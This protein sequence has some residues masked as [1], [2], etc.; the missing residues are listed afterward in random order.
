[1]IEQA[2]IDIKKVSRRGPSS[3]KTSMA[4]S[5]VDEFLGSGLSAAK[6]EWE[7]F[8]KDFD[9][10]KKAISYR[11]RWSKVNKLAGAGDLAMRSDRESGE[12]YLVHL[13]M[14]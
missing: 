6:V 12:V 10:A 1:M 8:A 3:Q 5:A 13:G 4:Q 14:F 2:D 7:S 11:V 9:G